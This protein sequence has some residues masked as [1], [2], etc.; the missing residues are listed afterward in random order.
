MPRCTFYPLNYASRHCLRDISAPDLETSQL[1]MSLQKHTCAV[2]NL[3]GQTK[4]SEILDQEEKL[5]YVWLSVVHLPPTTI[6][7]GLTALTDSQRLA[8]KKT[9][10][11]K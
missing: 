6:Y 1:L 11:I 4:F 8:E 3:R 10:E 2:S 5:Q 9:P 7:F